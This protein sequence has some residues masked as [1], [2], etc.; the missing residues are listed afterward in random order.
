VLRT[1]AQRDIRKPVI[2]DTRCCCACRMIRAHKARVLPEPIGPWM[3]S[4]SASDITK[5]QTLVPAS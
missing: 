5:S 2:L 3:T 4:T 1:I